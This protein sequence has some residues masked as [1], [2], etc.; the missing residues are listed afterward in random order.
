VR[1]FPKLQIGGFSRPMAKGLGGV[2]TETKIRPPRGIPFATSVEEKK[3]EVPCLFGQFIEARF[4]N[5]KGFAIPGGDP[6]GIDVYDCDLVVRTL[7]SNHC[8]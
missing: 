8:P 4:V 6:S 3:I 2:F 7:G 1:L 5:G